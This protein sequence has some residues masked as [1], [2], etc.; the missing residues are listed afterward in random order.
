MIRTLRP[1]SSPPDAGGRLVGDGV[2]GEDEP[3]PW[4]MTETDVM[5]SSV[6]PLT[7]GRNSDRR[8]A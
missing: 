1:N 2:L 6:T 3:R 4:S 5:K 8:M 7:T